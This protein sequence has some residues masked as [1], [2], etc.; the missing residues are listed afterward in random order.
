MSSPKI[1]SFLE[2]NRTNKLIAMAVVGVVL[3]A[4]IAFALTKAAGYFAAVEAD[5]ASR[6]ANARLVNDASA[7]GGEAIQFT[8]PPPPSSPPT[9]PTPPPAG[10]GGCPPFPAFPDASCTGWQHTG[11]TL[12]PYTGPYVITTP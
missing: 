12:T 1:L 5:T 10:G 4:G 9:P 11:V 2:T 3:C 7:S 6:T 8:A